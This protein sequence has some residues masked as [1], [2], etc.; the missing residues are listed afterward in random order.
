MNKTHLIE[1]V[2][3]DMNISKTQADQLI[4]SILAAVTDSL[5][6]EEKVILKDFGRWEVSKLKPR[7]GTHPQTGNLIIIQAKKQPRFI[8][9]KRLLNVLNRTR[10]ESIK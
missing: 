7:K 6:R 8:P 2:S 4:D 3:K 5:R 1:K 9:G 10:I